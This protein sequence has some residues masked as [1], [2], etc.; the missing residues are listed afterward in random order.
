LADI[1]TVEGY[2][3]IIVLRHFK[4][5]AARR[6]LLQPVFFFI[7]AGMIKDS[8]QQSA[9]ISWHVHCEQSSGFLEVASGSDVVYQTRI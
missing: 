8:I 5:G 1:T 7:K 2:T 9:L 4:S 3:D 6:H